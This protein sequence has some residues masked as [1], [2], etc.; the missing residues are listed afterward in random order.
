MPG[1][2]AE[3]E[4]QPG[5]EHV[6]RSLRAARRRADTQLTAAQAGIAYVCRSC[7]KPRS[8]FRGL[9]RRGGRRASAPAAGAA[10]ATD[11]AVRCSARSAAG[12]W[13][14]GSWTIHSCTPKPRGG[15]PTRRV[16]G[17]PPARQGR[18]R[19]RARFPPPDPSRPALPPSNQG[20][21]NRCPSLPDR[22]V[23]NALLYKS[24]ESRPFPH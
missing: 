3:A 24:A 22:G 13:G 7:C 18:G 2:P 11:Y 8:G 16:W 17:W 9:A 12:G 15:C 20:L 14:S 23:A 21:K 5:A 6:R 4:R 1:R 10:R 19:D